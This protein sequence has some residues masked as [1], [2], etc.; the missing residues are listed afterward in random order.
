MTKASFAHF[1]YFNFFGLF[2]RTKNSND[3]EEEK[4]DL[5]PKYDWGKHNHVRVTISV[6]KA[7]LDDKANDKEIEGID[8]ASIS[9]IEY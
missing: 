7:I 1:F 8:S 4:V 6:P 3:S 2:D 9:S 5:T